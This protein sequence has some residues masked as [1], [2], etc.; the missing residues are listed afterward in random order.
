MPRRGVA[1]PPRRR[2]KPPPRRQLAT[3]RASCGAR[4]ITQHSHS[5][6]NTPYGL[7]VELDTALKKELSNVTQ[8]C[9][10]FLF[11]LAQLLVAP[12]LPALEQT[13][14]DTR[15]ARARSRSAHAGCSQ[16]ARIVIYS[17]YC[18]REAREPRSGHAVALA[19]VD[20]TTRRRHADATVYDT[21]T[22]TT[23]TSAGGQRDHQPCEPR[24]PESCPAAA[25]QGLNRHKSGVQFFL[26]PR[27][28][29]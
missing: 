25:S 16:V 11:E 12:P 19:L 29:L 18:V 9:L 28:L 15:H 26:L 8:R 23:T 5:A 6:R 1:Q 24:E 20:A 21:T 4:G 14:F 2:A 17:P 10:Q 7:C 27:N 22:T 3:S 13:A